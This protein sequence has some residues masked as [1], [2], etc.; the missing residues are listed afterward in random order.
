MTKQK[1]APIRI[2]MWSGPR[3]IS[4]A[5]MRS[6]ESRADTAVVD[7]PF[8]AAYL[9]ATGIMHP[10]QSE[11]LASQS[12]DYSEV[13]KNELQNELVA[14][15]SIQY[16]K[17]MTQ[18]MVTDLDYD[19]FSSLRHAFLIRSPEQVVASYG[20]K[21]ESITADDIGFAKQKEIYDKVVALS[22]QKPP[23]IDARDVLTNPANVLQKLCDALNVAFDHNMLSWS[24]GPRDSD[25]VWAA[26]WYH[27]VEESTGFAS[28]QAKQID[29]SKQQQRVAD[30]SR[31][32]YQ[33]M[34]K[35]RIVAS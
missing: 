2:A 19:W 32:Y 22:G 23:V 7:E 26:H 15:Q 14:G 24:A 28:Y 25:G 33:E 4:T 31:P 20:V 35:E 16:Q 8:Y 5:M 13:I 1:P 21:R 18:H 12:S 6:W 10:M 9:T 30:Q 3:N 29:L 27:N 17:H 34:Y 11:V